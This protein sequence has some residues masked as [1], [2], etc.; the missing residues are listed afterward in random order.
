[1]S[2]S[3]M[4]LNEKNVINF[5]TCNSPVDKEGWLMKK[6][7]DASSHGRG[8]QRRYFTLKGNLLFYFEKKGENSPL[9][10]IIMEG[11][12]VELVEVQ[13]QAYTFG[14][15]FQGQGSR[16]Y[17]M[18]ADDQEVME[19]W[20]KVLSCATYEYMRLMVAELQRQLDDINAAERAKAKQ[21][22][23]AAAAAKSL[24]QPGTKQQQLSKSSLLSPGGGGGG[25]GG[26]SAVP[27][28]NT[29]CSSRA[30][31]CHSMAS[32][33]TSE[34]GLE[35]DDF[36]AASSGSSLS[37]ASSTCQTP[38][39]QQQMQRHQRLQQQVL[40]DNA[41]GSKQLSSS[42][43]P[44]TT[45]TTEKFP[46]TSSTMALKS[47][48]TTPSSATSCVSAA[49]RRAPSPSRL[50]PV[51]ATVVQEISDDIQRSNSPDD[52]YRGRGAS[53][54]SSSSSPAGGGRRLSPA[55]GIKLSP[56]GHSPLRGVSPFVDVCVGGRGEGGGTSPGEEMVISDM[57][58]VDPSRRTTCLSS[59]S[60]L[61]FIDLH[62]SFGQP[63]V[64]QIQSRKS[65]S[66]ALSTA[67]EDDYY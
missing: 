33:T 51:G 28:S 4:R 32:S 3:K 10:V 11:C 66:S 8:F 50:N 13:D 59:P 54:S 52:D 49:L 55:A 14:I 23:E 15:H 44:T 41:L 30:E 63:I 40:S 24:Q 36:F 19:S 58:I 46:A 64:D 62:R 12:T 67:S 38:P 5:S 26:P 48:I 21:L 53:P 27:Q 65:S 61:S 39:M 31:S 35:E 25:G 42:R 7:P 34:A 6:A 29:G 2:G 43:L 9:G 18:A 56:S 45:A 22:K 20:M 47:T 16:T 57:H 60:P 1:M 17:I 37:S